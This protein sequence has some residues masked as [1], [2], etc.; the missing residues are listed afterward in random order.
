MVPA[1]KRLKLIRYCYAKLTWL[2][3]IIFL[4]NGQNK[5]FALKRKK[6]STLIMTILYNYCMQNLKKSYKCKVGGAL[7]KRKFSKKKRSILT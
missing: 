5:S 1:G 2:M 6:E 3:S 7:G 4:S